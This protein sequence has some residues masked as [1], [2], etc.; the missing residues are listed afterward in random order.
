MVAEISVGQ[1]WQVVG[2]ELNRLHAQVR[3]RKPTFT[4]LGVYS[5]SFLWLHYISPLC[6]A[7]LS[8]QIY[9]PF[10]HSVN[11]IA[12]VIILSFRYTS[13]PLR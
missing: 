10:I 1:K 3:L 2:N 12:T 13:R 8:F 9:T 7:H 5:V 4:I 11:F 6:F